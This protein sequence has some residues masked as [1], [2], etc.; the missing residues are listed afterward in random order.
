VPG[1][2]ADA[3]GVSLEWTAPPE[4]PSGD[5][6][7]AR[8]LALVG[9][10][11]GVQATVEVTRAAAGLSC[12][13]RS[14][15]GCGQYHVALRVRVAGSIGERALEAPTCDVA[16]ESAAVVLALSAASMRADVAPPPAL[17]PPAPR[18]PATWH[19]ALAV[20]AT[21]DAGTL[22]QVAAGLDFR[23]TFALGDR[24]SAGVGGGLWLE[25]EGRLPDLPVQ[26]AHFVFGAGSVFG[27]Y[28]ALSRGSFELWPCA[29]LEIDRLS[30]TSVG[31][32]QPGTATAQWAGL[33]LGA[34]GR[35]EPFPWFALAL[36][37]DGVAS[38]QEQRFSISRPGGDLEAI[39][40]TSPV[41]ARVEMGPEVRF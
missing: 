30:A 36:E 28:R 37:V 29:L 24:V 6:V 33:G 4:C 18:G 41:V 35:W 17:R 16:A 20:E 26:G 31:T 9:P 23:M 14:L 38:T 1:S 39:Y 22:P 13:A 15:G 40:T 27:C 5:S 32:T 3:D 7:R 19:V 10:G 21:L 11:A 34:R 12:D 2:A 25:Q 8:V